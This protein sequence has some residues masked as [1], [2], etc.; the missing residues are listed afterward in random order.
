[1]TNSNVGGYSGAVS[2]N[3]TFTL[4]IPDSGGLGLIDNVNVLRDAVGTAAGS[5]FLEGTPLAPMT[6]NVNQSFER[7]TGG[8]VPTQDTDQNSTDFRRNGSQSFPQNLASVCNLCDGVTCNSAPNRQCW[9]PRGVCANG[10]CDYTERPN[11]AFCND[12]DACTVTDRCD[13]AGTCVSGAPRN[14]NN[15]PADFC[16]DQDTLVTYGAGTCSNPIGCSYP[17]TQ[18][19][20]PF[21]CDGVAKECAPDPCTAVSCTTPPTNGCYTGASGT[22]TGGSCDYP[23]EAAGTGCDDGDECTVGDAC[24]ADGTCTP[25]TPKVTD[26]NN[27]CTVDGCNPVTGVV[28]HVAVADATSCD[29]GDLCNG[30]ATCQAGTCSP[31]TAVTCTTPSN[32]DC[33]VSP[34]TCAALTGTCSYAKEPGGTLCSD[35]DSC[36]DND[37]C[38]GNGLCNGETV[39][40]TP[41][42]AFCDTDGSHTFSGG[43]CQAVSGSCGAYAETVTACPAGC[44][45]VSGLCNADPCIGKVCPA[46][47]EPCSVAA[48]CNSLT[49]ECVYTTAPSGAGCDDGDPCTAADECSSGGACAGVP[50]LCNDPDP[51]ECVAGKS[52][53]Y[54]VSGTCAAGSC[55]YGFTDTACPAGCNDTTGLCN[56]DP[57]ATV[58]CDSPTSQC[59]QNLGS[60]SAGICSYD[61]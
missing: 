30:F 12:S 52:R 2:G 7:L 28:S 20:C 50:L 5:A 48:G 18:T 13:G 3:R 54:D 33:E 58:T 9:Q 15:P 34:G 26:D 53:V 22:C 1:F 31:G 59:Q 49:G 23:K 46:P 6:A 29:D 47:T 4:G 45:A 44:D 21:G 55:T 36:T 56:A 14:C 37:E 57:C 61:L 35:G 43:S 24:E 27:P 42:N 60:C 32:A 16:L 40:C 25:G 8:C 51:S 17:D 19:D 10:V 41:P 11:N 39:V 38:D